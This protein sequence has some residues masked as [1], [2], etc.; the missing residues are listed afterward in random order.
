MSLIDAEGKLQLTDEDYQRWLNQ[1]PATPA[2]DP[3]SRLDPSERSISLPKRGTHKLHVLFSGTESYPGEWLFDARLVHKKLDVRISGTTQPVWRN[4]R[5]EHRAG[6]IVLRMP[7]KSES[8]S[9][10]VKVGYMQSQVSFRPYHL[11]PEI[12]MHQEGPGSQ[13]VESAIPMTSVLGTRVVIIGPDVIGA[14]NYIGQYALI[15]YAPYQLNHGE[16]CIQIINGERD[17]GFIGYFHQ[18]SL[19]RSLFIINT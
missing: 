1:P 2:W 16:T 5:Y 17:A 4:G 10:T 3:T 15:I 11:S 7:L 6:F 19:C 18:T 12:T 8:D 14:S 9:I 13:I